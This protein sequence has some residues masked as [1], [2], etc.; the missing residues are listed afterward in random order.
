MKTLKG[1]KAPAFL[2]LLLCAAAQSAYAQLSI[3]PTSWNV[4]GL[5]SNNTN[6]GPDNFPVGV[7]LCN[8]GGAAVT[9]V[10]LTFVWDTSNA[11]LSLAAGNTITVPSLAAGGCSDFYFIVNVTR[12]S[13][14]H[15]A[16][17]GY[18]I[19]ASGNGVA[20]VSTPTPRELYV[21]KLVSQNRNSI[22]SLSGAS[23]VYVGGTYTFSLSANTATGGYEQLEALVPFPG[24]IFQVLS[25]ATT[26]TAPPGGTNDKF[27]ADACGW[28]N[29]PTSPTY[30]SCVGPVNYPGGKAGGTI[31]TTYTVRVIAAGSATLS[32]LI[33]DFSGSS[34]HYNSDYGTSVLS[35]TAI[36]PPN[37]ALAKSH[38]GNFTQGQTGAAYTLAVSNV[39]GA[40]SSGAVTVTDTVPAGLTPTAAG[41]T[42]WTCGIAGQTVTC[43]RG[44]ALAAGASHPSLTLTVNVSASAPASV[45]N[46]ATVSGG[47]DITPANN[48]ATDPTTINT[49]PLVALVKSCP[50]PSDCT[51]SPQPPNTELTYQITFTNTGGTAAQGLVITDPVPANTDFKVG[52]VTTGLGTTGLTIAVE[53]SNDYDAAAPGSATWAYSPASGG[54]AAAAGYDRQVRAIRWRVTAGSLSQTAPGNTGSVSFTVLLR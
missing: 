16:K 50:S 37:L 43:S 38:T 27:Y 20:T 45:T 12:T 28:D 22:N 47:G 23:T 17:R 5:D 19:T 25:I 33:Y 9:N 51:S 10:T 29:V 6:T 14:A 49:P 42:G 34:Y 39:G 11:Y 35:V 31:N 30:R 8:T 32:A 36:D 7:R 40:P 53:Y 26:Y 44:D 2:L 48:T 13:A 4:I 1:I 52:S 46:S 21:E 3:T 15:N 41:G 18:H 24:A 54:G